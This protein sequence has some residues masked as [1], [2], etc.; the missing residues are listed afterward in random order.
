MGEVIY[1][2][3]FFSR[4]FIGLIAFLIM[5]VKIIIAY[6]S[7][8]HISFSLVGLKYSSVGIYNSLLLNI[9]SHGFV[10]LM[11]FFL[12]GLLYRKLKFRGMK[13]IYG[14]FNVNI[15]FGLRFIFCLFMNIGV[16]IFL[17]FFSEMLNYFVL[18]RGGGGLFFVLIALFLV[19]SLFNV[20]VFGGLFNLKRRIYLNFFFSLKEVGFLLR[21]IFSSFFFCWF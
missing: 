6:S 7:I 16:P 10:A 4:C 5:D 8:S 12:S 21:L 1:L 9:F 20:N 18:F 14:R 2:I 17:T 15:L 11:L 19:F 13:F 3:T